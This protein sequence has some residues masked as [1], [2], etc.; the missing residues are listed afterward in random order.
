MKTQDPLFILF[1]NG[2]FLNHGCEAILR[3]TIDILTEEFGPCR[4]TNSLF[5]WRELGFVD[6]LGAEVVHQVPVPPKQ[7]SQPPAKQVRKYSPKWFKRKLA[8]YLTSRYSK[9]MLPRPAELFESHLPEA[10]AAIAVGGDNYSLD[11]HGVA[12]RCFQAN[13]EVL[14]YNKPL[15]LWGASIGPFTKDRD[16]EKFASRELKKVSLV[17]ARESKTVEYLQSIGVSKNVRQVADPAFVLK[18]SPIENDSPELQMIRRPCIGMN[19]SPLMARYWNQTK[20]WE[21]CVYECII[22]MLNTFD[23]PIILVPH[24]I[25]PTNDDHHFMQTVVERLNVPQRRLI[26]IGREYDCMQLKWLIS[27]LTVFVGC[28]THATIASL[29]SSV[30]TLSI[31]Y[32]MKAEG[33]NKDIFGHNNWSIL[34]NELT[35]DSL[36]E[37]VNALLSTKDQVKNF[38]DQRMPAYK[39]QARI[40]GQYLKNLLIK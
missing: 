19:F 3:S 18:T 32:S 40:A 38:L 5:Y 6:N 24:V 22:E 26:L 29:S 7:Q 16:F 30:P 11:Y 2:P 13:A 4:F 10:I 15:V 1:G 39:A 14:K 34:L 31:A 25:C 23:L 27:H 35:P 21:D 9:Y 36:I 12:R 37:R 28:R 20:P 8:P 17:C 33:I